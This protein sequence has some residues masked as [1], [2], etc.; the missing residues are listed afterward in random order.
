MQTFLF[1]LIILE[2]P[3]L[4]LDNRSRDSKF[5]CA[6]LEIGCHSKFGCNNDMEIDANTFILTKYYK[7][8]T[9][10]LLLGQK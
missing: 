7:Y 4:R 3:I 9:Y 6:N 10:Y 5:G 8:C 1:I 2:H